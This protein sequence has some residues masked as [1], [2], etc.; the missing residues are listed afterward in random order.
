MALCMLAA[1]VAGAHAQISGMSAEVLPLNKMITVTAP[2]TP[3]DRINAPKKLSRYYWS[4]Y[5]PYV[6]VYRF[7]VEPG[8]KY[9]LYF[10]HPADGIYRNAMIKTET[11]L[12]DDLANYTREGSSGFVVYG[13]Q[14]WKDPRGQ[15]FRHSFTISPKSDN[16]NLYMI[17]QCGKPG[18]SFGVMLKSPPDSDE[19]VKK[20]TGNNMGTVW[21]TPLALSTVPGA[22]AGSSPEPS[23]SPGGA[24]IPT[25]TPSPV[26]TGGPTL[27]I[28]ALGGTW[29]VNEA[30]RWFG[31]W[32]RR[33]G[34]T[35]FDATWKNSTGQMVKDTITIESLKGYSIVLIRQGNGGRYYATLS[36][37]GKRITGGT[38]S[39]YKKGES[40]SATISR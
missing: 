8:R 20:K 35:V 16:N 25:A 12:T 22:G 31:T 34:T 23:P 17:L 33:P 11:P 24:V 2:V 39:W 18:V 14:P 4:S 9:T 27:T 6:K 21:T 15:L 10:Q 5:A 36:A 1:S 30:G 13:Q 26:A 38:A 37:D 19:D 29:T 40:W 32:I 28:A 7:I 3:L